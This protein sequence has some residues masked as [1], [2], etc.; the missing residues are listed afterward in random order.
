LASPEEA[1]MD[2]LENHLTIKNRQARAV[3]HIRADYQIKAV[4]GRM[5][6]AGM[7]EQVPGTRTSSTAYRKVQKLVSVSSAVSFESLATVET[8]GNSS[9]SVGGA[10]GKENLN[11]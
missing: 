5:V 8:N 1:I 6:A 4:F 9:S 2:Y 10:N 7:I 11:N 3:T